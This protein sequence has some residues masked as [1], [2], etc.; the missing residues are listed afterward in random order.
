MK[1]ATCEVSSGMASTCS[2]ALTNVLVVCCCCVAVFG[3]GVALS[4]LASTD[5]D[6]RALLA[7]GVPLAVLGAITTVGCCVFLRVGGSVMIGRRR[8]RAAAVRRILALE[9]S[10]EDDGAMLL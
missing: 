1:R 6:S 2:E 3:G 10:D 7:L 9:D 8:R 5:E 4:V